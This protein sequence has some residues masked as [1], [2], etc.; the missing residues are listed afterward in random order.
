MKAYSFPISIMLNKPKQARHRQVESALKSN[1][2][3]L[4]E[5]PYIN[6]GMD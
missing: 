1:L 3:A 2:R 6:T 4:S 5:I